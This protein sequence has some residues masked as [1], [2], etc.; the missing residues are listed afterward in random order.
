L[1]T[2]LLQLASMGSVLLEEKISSYREKSASRPFDSGLFIHAYQ[3]LLYIFR[4]FSHPKVLS[5][6]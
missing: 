2:I 3:P 6:E 4:D 5:I 1:F